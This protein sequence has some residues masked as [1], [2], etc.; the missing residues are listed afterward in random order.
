[1]TAYREWGGGTLEY[2]CKPLDG[3]QKQDFSGKRILL[4]EDN[5][6]NAEIATEILQMTGAAIEHVWNG[7]EAVDILSTVPDGHYD[8]VFMDIQMP[9][10]NGYEAASA[11]RAASSEYLRCIPIVAMS[12]NTF[13]EDI[14]MSLASG[15]N[16]H[17][18]KPLDFDRLLGVLNEYL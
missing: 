14:Q 3:Y 2:A 12:A 6:I 17:I 13:A 10:K 5:D 4:V 18:A 8:L 9:V 7:Q 15:M 11:I 1:M 16:D